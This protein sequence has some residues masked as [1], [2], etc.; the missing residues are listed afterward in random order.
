VV[1]EEIDV[2]EVPCLLVED[3]VEA[4]ATWIAIDVNRQDVTALGVVIA[5][6]LAEGAQAGPLDGAGLEA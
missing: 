1:A 2:G 5:L 6:D 3:L 4:V